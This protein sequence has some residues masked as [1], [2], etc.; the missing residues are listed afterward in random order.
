M[1]GKIRVLIADD[2]PLFASGLGMQLDAQPDICCIGVAVDGDD[3]VRLAAELH[4]DVVLM[5]IRM[6]G[7][8]GIRATESI[9]AREADPPAVVMLTTIRRDEA[10]YLAL[11]A[12]A[13]GFLTKDA[14]P[15]EVMG[16]IRAV[17]AGQE[18]PPGESIGEWVPATEAAAREDA[19]APLSER[20]KEVFL[21]MAKGLSNSE[22]A[23]AT[24]LGET[25]VKTHV[26]AVLQKL[27]LRSR[28]QVVV[29]AYENG[30]VGAAG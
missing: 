22:I 5:D 1:S 27:G 10:V 21:L 6:P 2:Q 17:H 20:E 9:V 23:T 7:G 12:G 14:T 30:L 19:I 3:A 8:G 4:P 15:H 28:V 13:A 24:Y 11:R 18:L 29:F 26:R 16:T 25:T